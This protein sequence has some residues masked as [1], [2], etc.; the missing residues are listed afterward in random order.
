MMIILFG[1]D[2]SGKSTIA[3][4]MGERLAD[5]GLRVRRSWMRGSH[6]FAS[7]LARL[8]SRLDAFKG[9]DNPYYGIAIP[10]GLRGLWQLIEFIS[11]IP[12]ILARFLLPGL[13]GY[14]VVAERYTPDFVAWVSLTTRDDGYIMGL[15]SRFML[16]LSMHASKSIYVTASLQEILKRRDED[17]EFIER[18]LRLYEAIS[19]YLNPYRLDTTG[20]KPEESLKELEALLS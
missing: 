3:K 16:A 17:A 5:K 12:V 8:L 18:Q 9:E 1:P 11:A 4:L 10:R 7:L 2:G 20:K 19:L 14:C 15:Q 13:L 6:T